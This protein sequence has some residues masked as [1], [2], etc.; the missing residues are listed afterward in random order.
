MQTECKMNEIIENL[1]NN[2]LF[3]LSLGSK[4]LF[5][6]N[7]LAWILEQRN[8]KGEFEAMRIF[9]TEFLKDEMPIITN[10][11]EIIIAREEKK[12]DLILKWKIKDKFNYLFIENKLKSIPTNEQLSDYNKVV[13]SYSIGEAILNINGKEEK[14]KRRNENPKFLLTP[15]HSSLETKDW[16]KITYKEHIIPFLVR[17]IDLEFENC[18]TNQIKLVIDRYIDFLKNLIELLTIFDID[19]SNIE[20]FKQRKYNFYEHEQYSILKKLRLHDFILKLAHSYIE[21]LISIELKKNN[22]IEKRLYSA[23][24]NAT[25]MTTVEFNIGKSEFYIGLQLQG[26][27]LRYYLLSSKK[28]K[29]IQLAKRLFEEKLWFHDIVT[30]IPL[31]G[32]GRSKKIK[33]LGL[34]DNEGNSRT[35]CEYNDGAFLYF[36]KDLSKKQSNCEYSINEIIELIM[37]SIE[38][39]KENEQKIITLIDTL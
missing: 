29:N 31:E 18:D 13:E 23:F 7:L 19:T 10:P 17:I 38:K 34:T 12:I 30:D 21:N 39:I 8:E 3:Q 27:Q 24:T 20:K 32:N 28:Q 36:Y 25:G 22:L 14:L 2:F 35:F 16:N 37:L 26:L 15:I 11:E 1:K 5:H 6:S 33:E 4:E 9:V